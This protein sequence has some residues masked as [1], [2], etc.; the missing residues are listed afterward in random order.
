VRVFNVMARNGM[1]ADI[2]TPPLLDIRHLQV[3][4]ISMLAQAQK[5]VRR[6][7][8]HLRFQEQ[9]GLGPGMVGRHA[10]GEQNALGQLADFLDGDQHG[11]NIL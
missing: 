8:P 6:N 7:R 9:A 10:I 4:F 2:P 3:E 1:F 11:S 5:A